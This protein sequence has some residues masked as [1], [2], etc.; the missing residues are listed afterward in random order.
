MTSDTG[1]FC[2]IAL[3]CMAFGTAGPLP[4]VGSGI[5]RKVFCIVLPEFGRAPPGSRGM[6]FRASGGNASNHMVGVCS[7][8]IVGFMTG[9]TIRRSF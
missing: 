5:N 6:T 9:K 3:G 4:I 7:G 8:Q 2:E 1:E